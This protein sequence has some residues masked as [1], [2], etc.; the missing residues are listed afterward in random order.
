[1]TA[2]STYPT[3]SASIAMHFPDMIRNINYE[4]YYTREHYYELQNIS[5]NDYCSVVLQIKHRFLVSLIH[6]SS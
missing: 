3:V 2:F 4:C 5:C 6:Q 1:M